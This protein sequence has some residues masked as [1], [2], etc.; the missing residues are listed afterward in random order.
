MRNKKSLQT[1]RHVDPVMPIV[2]RYRFLIMLCVLLVAA[3]A[4]CGSVSA[5]NPDVS[6]AQNLSD[7]LNISVT[8][9]AYAD[10]T[11]VYL[12]RDVP[13]NF[14]INITTTT[15]TDTITLTTVSTGT[16]NISRNVSGVPLFNV[17]SGTLILR[18]NGNN[19]LTIDGNK[20]TYTASSGGSSLV[21]VNGGIFN[22]SDGAVLQNS[23]TATNGGAVYMSSGTFNMNGGNITSNTATIDGGGVYVTNS[24][25]FT[26]SGSST[27]SDNTASYGGGV[28]TGGTFNMTGGI[29]S[30][31]N[32]AFVAGGVYLRSSIFNISGSAKVDADNDIRLYSGTFI[33]V[34]GALVSTDVGAK[35]ITP[36][37]TV[38]G[39]VLVT[40]GS[41]SIPDTWTNN[42]AL[43]T[44][45]ALIHSL[46]LTNTSNQLLLVTNCT[47]RFYNETDVVYAVQYAP[48]G[49]KITEPSPAP[50]KT[51]YTLSGWNNTTSGNN[52]LWSFSTDRVTVNPTNL[53]ANWT[54]NPTQVPT[55][56]SNGDGGNDGNN[57]DYGPVSLN[58]TF[59]TEDGNL[60]L[61]YPAGSNIM[62]TV[63]KDYFNGA[64]K[65]P[66]ISY[67]VVYDVHSTAD[68]G[69]SVTLVFR[70]NASLLE[71][72]NLTSN[73]IAILHYYDGEWHQ[74]TIKSIQLVDGVYLFT[75]ITSDKTSP[76][77]IAYNVDGTWV[78]LEEATTPTSTPTTGSTEIV[79]TSTTTPIP[80]KATSSP[81]PL[82]GII[83]GLGAAVLLLRRK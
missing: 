19:N 30:G 20:S 68:S 65:P 50:T 81:V 73:D 2:F 14:T 43:N 69:T 31:N 60:T 23:S 82:V 70:V 10:G 22:M 55:S 72:M 66:G 4:C 39:T 5:D 49:S 38:N 7:A 9:A 25:T 11:T 54:E 79:P 26:M 17:S 27:I 78:K 34:T 52:T 71:E 21:K 1:R 37:F 58:G 51:G 41:F 24:G 44:S 45:W 77:M 76:F 40:Y 16:H 75:V 48:S 56:N 59:T 29:I 42:F 12:I 15:T 57:A 63:F 28:Y 8:D 35:N 33:T 62:V 46:T 61:Y 47:V 80:T 53:S 64:E 74:M 67:L 6:N 3:G 83:A 32:A 18:G 13:L 36:A